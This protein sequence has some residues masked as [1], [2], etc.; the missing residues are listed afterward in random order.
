M[1][2]NDSA[3]KDIRNFLENNMREDMS[4]EQIN[5]L[6][7]EFMKDYNNSP[8]EVITEKNAK[9]SDDFL[10][11]AQRA[12]TVQEALKFGRKAIKLD[13]DNLDAE[14]LVAELSATN[15]VDLVKK[16][17]RAVKHG[18]EVMT[19]QGYMDKEYEGEFWLVIETRP[20]MRMRRSYVDALV[21]CG[22]IGK[23]ISECEDLL[24][25]CANDNLGVRF[26]LMHLYALTE[27]EEDALALHTRFNN[28]NETQMLLPLSILYFKK[29]DLSAAGKYADKL[30]RANKDFKLFLKE[31]RLGKLK[32]YEKGMSEYGY[33][34]N[35]IEELIVELSD[36]AFLFDSSI[37]YLVWAENRFNSK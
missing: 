8:R 37:S 13:P 17:D 24:R 32:K 15:S 28:D 36:N 6:L 16:L 7:A 10:E 27:R 12:G 31:L 29:Y 25:L 23:A 4:E 1:M 35:T 3:M 19:K 14:Q 21:R 26:I 11:L 20:Y 30:A 22:M 34:P 5:S 9:T 18:N 33:K 2:N